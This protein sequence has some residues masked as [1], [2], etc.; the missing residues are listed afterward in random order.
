MTAGILGGGASVRV[1][2]AIVSAALLSQYY[3]ATT[4]VIAP[5]LM[6]DIG[7]SAE[8]LGLLSGMFFVVLTAMQIP[9]GLM[10]DRWGPRRT[11]GGLTAV[12]VA[13]SLWFALATTPLELIGAR[14]LIGFGCA[15]SFMGA[16][17][18]CSRW[19]AAG[20]FTGVLSLVFALSNIGTLMATAP[21]AAASEL[22]G[23]RAAFLASAAVTALVGV[24]FWGLVRDAPPGHPAGRREPERVGAVARGLAEVWRTPGLVPVLGLHTVAY[25]AMLT[26]LGLWAGPYLNDVHGLD[27]VARGNVVLL[28]AC[29]QIAGLLFYG[30]LDRLLDTRKHVVMAGAAVAMT[31]LAALALI[32]APPLVLAASLLVLLCFASGYTI[33][34]VAHGRSLFPDR[35][36]GRGV[37]TVNLGQAIG[38]ALLPIATG[39]I[40]G[41]LTPPGA[42]TAPEVAYRA[43]FACLALV[44]LGGLA[45]YRRSR[46]VKP[47]AT[48]E[49][50]AAA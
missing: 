44:L 6:A 2:A 25:A 47:G 33:V 41:G 28:M 12:A 31:T 40:V 45:V 42:A 14:V 43:A 49:G 10:F 35:L 22:L 16:V 46:D 24:A 20:R 19:Y 5:E 36:I 15:G 7:L 27:A 17:V 39:A 3:R 38:A 9:V 18:L 50:E 23:W 8:Q 30:P 37:T 4:G 26:V 1:F 29:G 48:V 13:G 11:V 34:I 32:P 21:L